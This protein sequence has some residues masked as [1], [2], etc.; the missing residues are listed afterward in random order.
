MEPFVL[1]VALAAFAFF[2]GI[3]GDV[4]GE[5]SSSYLLSLSFYFYEKK[6]NDFLH[7]FCFSYVA[8]MV[9]H[10]GRHTNSDKL[11]CLP[12]LNRSILDDIRYY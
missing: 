10:L 7:F 9:C 1:E 2:A 12:C 5:L 3:F 11:G 6:N 8:D 4:G